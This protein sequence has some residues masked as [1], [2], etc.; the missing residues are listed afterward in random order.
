MRKAASELSRHYF[1]VLK[2]KRRSEYDKYVKAGN[3]SVEIGYDIYTKKIEEVK[4]EI[5]GIYYTIKESN[6]LSFTDLYEWHSKKYNKEYAESYSYYYGIFQKMPFGYSKF[7][8]FNKI[9]DV[10]NKLKLY[11]KEN[12][13]SFEN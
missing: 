5:L 1:Y 6:K 8:T 12:N 9:I 4:N 13:V 2:Y 10:K 11:I 7:R 3:G